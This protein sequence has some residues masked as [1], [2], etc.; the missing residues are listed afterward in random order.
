MIS[1]LAYTNTRISCQLSPN[2]LE[3]EHKLEATEMQ[4]TSLTFS[5]HSNA[6]NSSITKLFLKQ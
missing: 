6:M 2:T 5:N 4:K 1:G 3:K